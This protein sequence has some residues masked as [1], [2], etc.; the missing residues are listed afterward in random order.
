MPW[1]SCDVT[2]EIWRGFVSWNHE[3]ISASLVPDAALYT[4][5]LSLYNIW[6]TQTTQGSTNETVM[7]SILFNINPR[8][9]FFNIGYGL[10]LACILKHSSKD[11]CKSTSVLLTHWGLNEIAHILQM[12]FKKRI[13]CDTELWSALV[14]VMACRQRGDKPLPEPKMIQFPDAYTRHQTSMR[15]DE[16]NVYKS[17]QSQSWNPALD[18]EKVD[19]L[20]HCHWFIYT[21]LA[22]FIPRPD[23][24]R[25]WIMSH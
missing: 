14:Q 1:R 9:Q 7:I 22:P 25:N 3:N 18:E 5:Q 21:S 13:L 12:A 23:K 24:T 4:S 6:H 16:W 19:S 10:H 17:G 20:I 8:L 2:N 11:T 15:W